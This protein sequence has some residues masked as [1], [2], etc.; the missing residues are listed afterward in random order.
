MLSSTNRFTTPRVSTRLL[1]ATLL[2]ATL[3]LGLAAGPSQAQD[4]TPITVYGVKSLSGSNA[5]YGKYAEMGS[6]LAVDEMSATL[7]RQI[8]YVSIDTEGNAGRAVRKV[9]EAIAQDGARLFNGATLSS[10]ALAVGKEVNSAGGVFMT[11]AGADEITGSECNSAT[12]RWSVPT[13]GAI[14]QTLVPYI[15]SHPD[16][17]RFYT[18]TP[19]YVFGE[20]LLRNAEKIFADKGVEHVGNSY[21]SLQEQEFSGY[22][23][24]A[25]AANPDVLVLLN[26]GSQSSNALRQAVNFG[27][28]Q[29][30][31]IIMVW[32]SGLEQLQELGNDNI[33][34]IY[35][36]AQYWHEVDTPANRELVKKVK[37]AYGI[38]PNYPLAADYT[39]T[40]TL[41][42]AVADSGA[43]QGETL[44]H[45][46][47]GRT[48]Q[49]PTGEET[50]RAADHQVLKDYYLLEGKGAA[51][52]TDASDY[53]DIVSS[54][55]SFLSPA[56]SGCHL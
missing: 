12:F 27:L 18:I 3:G 1:P 5:S 31:D 24:N 10:T 19:Q 21:H 23:T 11:P 38:T 51:E 28:N 9:Q 56:Q 39:M 48:Y 2:A 8:D 26:F 4:E 22:L 52:M 54:G 30:M 7:G 40:K 41:L 16:A 14:Q 50:I 43:T 37:E 6:K 47:E 35:F 32:S 33:D 25:M 55:Q 53:A 44:I 29:Q 49:G 45:A 34:G 15:D 13:Y 42:Q 36:G 17:K 46:L 20:A